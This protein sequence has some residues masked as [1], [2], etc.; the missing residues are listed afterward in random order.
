MERGT[1]PAVTA[2][3][4]NYNGRELLDVILPS[5]RPRRIPA[6]P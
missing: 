2:V 4:L 1:A 6:F 5:L 3:V